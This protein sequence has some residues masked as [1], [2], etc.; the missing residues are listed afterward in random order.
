[1]Y[2]LRRSAFFYTGSGRDMKMPFH[3]Q[4]Q[5]L[6]EPPFTWYLYLLFLIYRD[7]RRHQQC[8]RQIDGS[9]LLW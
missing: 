3:P 2:A 5:I 6:R 1:M 4:A 9:G 8:L 7:F